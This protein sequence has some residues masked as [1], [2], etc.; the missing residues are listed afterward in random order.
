MVGSSLS[1]SPLVV[2]LDEP[3]EGLDDS[4]KDIL[5]N[6]IRSLSSRNHAILM[7]THDKDISSSAD[8]VLTIRDGSIEEK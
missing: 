6:W 5:R 1:N 2:L 7:A 3:S 8:R 4:A